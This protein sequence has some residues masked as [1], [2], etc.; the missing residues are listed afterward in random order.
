MEAWQ[1]LLP[2]FV[3]TV[4]M[5]ITHSYLGLHVLA[6]GIIFVDLA[7]AQIA[8]LGVSI[9]F[10]L[11]NDAHGIESK[12][13]AFIATLIAALAFT[14]LHKISS[15][16]TREVTIGSVYV[17]TTALSLVILSRSS[18]GMEQLKSLFNGN[19]LWVDWQDIIVVAVAYGLLIVLHVIKRK[20]F[21]ALSFNTNNDKNMSF[22]WDFMFFASFAIVITLA[23]NIAG[24]LMVFALLIIPGFSATLLASSFVSRLT[25]A[26]SLA[27]SSCTFGLWLSF[28]ADLPVGATVVSVTGLLPVIALMLNYFLKRK[29]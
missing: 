11:G 23:V 22:F 29:L 9:A 25:V 18:Q 13:Y 21:Y 7:L 3:M 5:I 16:T 14:G 6:R 24:I 26:W 12:I 20:Q 8:G 27:V 1:L 17:V 2:S 28:K 4:M 15:K 10:L 19:I